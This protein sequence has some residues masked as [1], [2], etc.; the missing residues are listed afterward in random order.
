MGDLDLIDREE[1]EKYFQ[2]Y[3]APNNATLFLVGDFDPKEALSLIRKRF[4]SIPRGPPIPP[5]PEFEPEQLGERRAEV[6]RP[7]QSPSLLIG[8]KGPVSKDP[9]T[10]VLDVI[11]YALTVGEGSR[12]NR[13]LVFGQ[14]LAVAAHVD[15]TWRTGPGVFAIFLELKPGAKTAAVEKALYA[16]LEKVA[17]EGLPEGELTR[18]KNNLRAQMLRELSTNSRRADMLGNYELLLGSWKTGLAL[19]QSY[20]KVTSEQIR[21]VAR[22]YLV[23]ERRSVVTL[24]PQ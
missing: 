19:E 22:T 11:Q 2:T 24:V 16:E 12:L 14:E 13:A 4:G 1:C 21:R 23:A 15:W 18:V 17:E 6:R 7:A 20:A 10:L 9:D 5:V 3:Y 8:Y